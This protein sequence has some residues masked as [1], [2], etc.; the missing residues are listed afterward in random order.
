MGSAEPTYYQS[1]N[2][3]QRRVSGS[4]HLIFYLRIASA[5]SIRW[6]LPLRKE[7]NNIISLTSKIYESPAS[8]H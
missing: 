4:L 1:G 8:L 7:I 2:Q 3:I 5:V 6:L